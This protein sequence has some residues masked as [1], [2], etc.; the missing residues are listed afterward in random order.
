MMAHIGA[1]AIRALVVPAQR[2]SSAGSA[3]STTA[4]TS[5]SSF[6]DLSMA[7]S[8][9]ARRAAIRGAAVDPRGLLARARPESLRIGNS[10]SSTPCENAFKAMYV[11]VSS[12]AKAGA[13][14]SL[15]ETAPLTP[16]QGGT[17]FN[18]RW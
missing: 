15:P 4:K 5:G 13:N 3:I 16:T 12:L 9:A 1:V 14:H 17:L 8:P 7:R 18:R 2:S 11:A 10:S 6:A